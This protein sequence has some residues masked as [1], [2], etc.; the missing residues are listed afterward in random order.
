M[1]I[2]YAVRALGCIRVVRNIVATLAKEGSV[3]IS[4]II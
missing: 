4:S 3:V 2:E 1:K